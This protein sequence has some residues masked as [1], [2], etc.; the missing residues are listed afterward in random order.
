MEVQLLCTS[1]ESK[2]SADVVLH[3]ADPITV[4]IGALSQPERTN[5]P[6]RASSTYSARHISRPTGQV[7]SLDH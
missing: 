7:S 2:N 6:T 5:T 4:K 3:L 1:T